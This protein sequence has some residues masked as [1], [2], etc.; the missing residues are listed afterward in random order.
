[1]N[2]HLRSWIK[3][4]VLLGKG[5]SHVREEEARVT[6][7]S[8]VPLS[9]VSGPLS[10]GGIPLPSSQCPLFLSGVILPV[11]RCANCLDAKSLYLG[12]RNL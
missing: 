5:S 4:W 3:G 11:R 12:L 10:V 1:M 2:P 9:G 8:I 6:H 7:P